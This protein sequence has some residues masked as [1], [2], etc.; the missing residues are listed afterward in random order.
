MHVN[1]LSYGLEARS[2]PLHILSQGPFHK[3]EKRS[4]L[5]DNVG[6][7]ENLYGRGLTTGKGV[8]GLWVSLLGGFSGLKR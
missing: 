7:L 8:K 6:S 3:P 2:S 5:L 4:N 1:D